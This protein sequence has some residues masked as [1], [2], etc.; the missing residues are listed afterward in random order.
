MIRVRPKVKPR[1][2]GLAMNAEMFPR[3][4]SPASRKKLPVSSTRPVARASL[5]LAS[6]GA[7]ETVAAAS[8]AAEDEVAE[9]MAKRLRPTSP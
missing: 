1:S 7:R 3:R 4:A 8:T 2:T 6:P 5:R 9:T